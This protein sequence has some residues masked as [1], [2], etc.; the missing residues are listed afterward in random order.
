MA[1]N[2]EFCPRCGT[3][4]TSADDFCPNCGYDLTAYRQRVHNQQ[5][6]SVAGN[7]SEPPPVQATAQKTGMDKKSFSRK[8]KIGLLLTAGVLILLVAGYSI[9]KQYFSRE[10]QLERATASFVKGDAQTAVNYLTT[11][12]TKLSL[13][14]EAVAPLLKMYRKTPATVA[15]MKQSAQKQVDPDRSVNDFA[16]VRSGQRLLIFPAYRFKF[17]AVYPTLTTNL[18][19]TKV[20]IDGG[21]SGSA[22]GSGK[23]KAQ[24]VGP[25]V[26]G[27]YT[28]TTMATAG[29]KKVKSV[30]I[31][32][33]TY[34]NADLDLTFK[35]VSFTAAGYPGSEVLINGERMGEIG[36]NGTLAIKE[37]PLT[38]KTAK[39]TQVFSANGKKLTSRTVD[40]SDADGKRVKVGYPGVISHDDA[41]DLLRRAFENVREM[42]RFETVLPGQ[43]EMTNLFFEGG[44]KNKDY[45]QL[46][47]TM[48]D[49]RKSKDIASWEC[50]AR[51]KHVYPLEEG[52]ASVEFEV[53]WIFENGSSSDN[54]YH[55]QTFQYEGQIDRDPDAK[56]NDSRY[57]I[58][59]FASTKKLADRHTANGLDF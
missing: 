17:K 41:A 35:V 27:R 8:K 15:A 59:G 52:Q 11:D 3:A 28:I 57:V 2:Q 37:Y 26:P 31:H 7:R 4:V 32:D 47:L 18:S 43:Q 5:E 25:L 51:L 50:R 55:V 40:I 19:S 10:N 9:G 13:S 38:E 34:S 29:G 1:G 49:Y 53:F 39:M 23:M 58:K 54:R 16:F 33:L 44:N 56:G 30:S 6:Q 24:K 45:K 36:K 48:S 42:A 14:D 22:G 21:R 20:M 12:D 46:Y